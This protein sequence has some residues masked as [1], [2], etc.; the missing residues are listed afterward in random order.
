MENFKQKLTKIKTFLFDVDGVLTD[1]KVLVMQ[2]GEM[3]RNLNSKDGYALQ[4]A[5]KKGYRIA[6][7][8][9]GNSLSV[10][11]AMHNLGVQDVFLSQHDKLAC[12][13]DYLYTNDL[14][15]EEILYM[16]D[17]LPDYEVMKRVGIAACPNNAAHEI[18]EISIYISNRNGGEACVRDVIEQVM[19]SQG[20]WEIAGW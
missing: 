15:E 14:K 12:Y 16:G 11:T 8:T 2:N 5:I 4:L 9:G 18:K 19:R 3:L 20:T 10:K 7:I 6:I 1:G 17:D 13:K